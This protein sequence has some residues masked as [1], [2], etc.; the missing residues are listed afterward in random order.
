MGRMIAPLN[1]KEDAPPELLLSER[2]AAFFRPGGRLARGCAGESFGYE[3]RP[4]QLRMAEAVAEAMRDREHLAV[5]AGTGVGK[6]FA[7]LAPAIYAARAR[8]VKAVVSTFTI[9]LQEQLMF[10]DVP[11]LQQHLDESFTAALVKGRGNYLCRRRLARANRMSR[12]LFRT[13][14]EA[15]LELL[16]AWAERTTEGSLQDLPRQPPP[17]VWEAV[18][19]EEGN[20]LGARCPQ[21]ERCFFARARRQ[22]AEAD[23]LIVNHHL[24]FADLALREQDSKLLPDHDLVVLDEAHEVEDVAADHLGLRLSESSFAYWLRRLYSA[25]TGK[26]LLAALRHTAGVAAVNRTAEAVAGFFRQ[27]RGWAKLDEQTG[28]RLVSKPPAIEHAV[29]ATGGALDGVLRE[30]GESFDEASDIEM[31]SELAYLRRRGAALRAGLKDW[32]AQQ[33][34]DQVYWVETEGRRRAL[35]L[36]SAPVDVAPTLREKFFGARDT[37]I[38]TSATLAVNRTLDYFLKRVGAEQARQLVVGTPFDYARQM[39]VLIPEKMPEPTDPEKFLPAAAHAI[40]FFVRRSGGAAF[41]LFTNAAH[42]KR[43]AEETRPELEAA[44]LKLLV[45]GGEL[46][47]HAML[48][49]FRQGGGY[50]LFGLDSFWMG[51]DVRGDALRNVIITRLPFAVPDHPLTQARMERIQQ[52]GGDAFKEFSLPEAVIKFRQGVGR[53]IRTATDTGVVVVLDRR[54]A[55]KWYGRWFLRSLPECP[56]ET[57]YVPGAPG[58]DEP[59]ESA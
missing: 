41:V 47:R 31:K 23:L 36:Y 53:L 13:G 26:G 51:V 17:E 54:L 9:S 18:C 57:V 16:R 14:L 22:M 24:L 43:L 42:M 7:Y 52:R 10:K 29:D 32:L 19:A 4:Q 28:R 56:V 20:C 33:L 45:Q 1:G 55:S 35:T 59:G 38:L 58:A 5:E 49:Q 11:F 39:R 37:V 25:D 34:E 44:G 40:R 12:D 3:P 27:A 48:A 30:I 2:V 46:S 6:S 15:E 50:V 8:N 21:Q